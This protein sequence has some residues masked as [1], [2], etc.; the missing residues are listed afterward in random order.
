MPIEGLHTISKQWLRCVSL[1]L[2]GLVGATE[3][4]ADNIQTESVM[5]M[6]SRNDAVCEESEA[7][8]MIASIPGEETEVLLCIDTVGN[9][10]GELLFNGRRYGYLIDTD[11][12]EP[13]EFVLVDMFGTGKHFNQYHAY[14]PIPA[15]EWLT[16]E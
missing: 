15:P 10:F 4:F 11:G 14:N 12:S 9:Q 5:V 8:D 1:A 7:R 16:E 13:M 2:I 6:P 3:V